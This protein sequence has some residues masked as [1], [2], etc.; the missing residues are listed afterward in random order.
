MSQ[1]VLGYNKNQDTGIWRNIDYDSSTMPTKDICSEDEFRGFW[2][3]YE[4]GEC[5]VGKENEVT[6]ILIIISYF[7]QI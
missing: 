3:D 7:K 6:L 2:I 5:F 4:G 1:V